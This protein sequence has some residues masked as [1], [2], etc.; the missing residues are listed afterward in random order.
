MLI[1]TKIDKHDEAYLNALLR[2]TESL[3]CDGDCSDCVAAR[4]YIDGTCDCILTKL[5]LDLYEWR[6]V[7]RFAGEDGAHDSR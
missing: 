6:E 3:S 7:I 4:R 5:N 1:L 2:Y